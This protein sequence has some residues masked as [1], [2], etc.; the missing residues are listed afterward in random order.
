MNELL[1]NLGVQWQLLLAQV[2]NFFILLVLLKKFLYKPMLKFLRERRQGI[3]EGLKKSELADQKFTEMRELQA[4]EL[5]KTRQEAQKI[6]SEAKKR[7]EEAKSQIM[8]QAKKETE[9]LFAKAEK[10]MEQVKTQ[11]IEQAEQEIGRLAIEGM[12]YLVREKMSQEQRTA[13]ADEAIQHVKGLTRNP[14]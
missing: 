1:D 10:D 6:I 13:L 8:A 7:A 14:T 5:S 4:R 9:S 3:E 11:R 2:V 12:E